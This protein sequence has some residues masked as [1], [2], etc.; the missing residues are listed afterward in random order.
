MNSATDRDPPVTGAAF[1]SKQSFDVD[2]FASSYGGVT[3]SSFKP[4]ARLYNQ[5]EPANC[6]FYILNGQVQL[7]V[8]SAQGKEAIIALLNARDFSGEGCLISERFQ[9][10]T[11]TCLTDCVVAR[12]ERA[13]VT[14]AVQQDP[15][16]AEFF[17]V[18][19]LNRTVELRTEIRTIAFD[20]IAA[21]SNF[22]DVLARTE[23]WRARH[24][25]R[26]GPLLSRR[27]VDEDRI[28]MLVFVAAI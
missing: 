3:R 1:E 5:G 27:L 9:V 7:S 4:G 17:L 24:P 25:Q 15:R 18:Y 28:S 2:S 19:V 12:L 21:T 20:V 11:A 6:L 16:F 26:S 22:S 13:S 14:R 10:L 23:N 8:V